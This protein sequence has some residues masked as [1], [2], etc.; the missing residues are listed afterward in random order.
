MTSQPTPQEPDLDQVDR[1]RVRLVWRLATGLA[2]AAVIIGVLALALA[3]EVTA[4]HAAERARESQTAAARAAAQAQAVCH[5]VKS[6][7]E[8]PLPAA[9]KLTPLGLSISA[10]ARIAYVDAGCTL[11]R[12][13][14]ADPQLLPYLPAGARYR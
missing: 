3:G 5:L 4:S 7:A 12:L 8:A 2:I 14:K 6:V 10:G 1:A 13:A 9:P 11:G